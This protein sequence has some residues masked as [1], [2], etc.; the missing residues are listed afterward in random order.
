MGLIGELGMVN[1]FFQI[2]LKLRSIQQ[3]RQG[4]MARLPHQLTRE[5][6]G[7]GHLP[8]H[9]HRTLDIPLGGKVGDYGQIHGPLILIPVAQHNQTGR[10]G[11]ALTGQGSAH[12]ALDRFGAVVPQDLTDIL[13]PLALGHFG[14]PTGE[15]FGCGVEVLNAAFQV[16]QDHRIVDRCQQGGGVSHG[17]GRGEAG[18]SSPSTLRFLPEI[19]GMGITG[20]CRGLEA[21]TRGLRSGRGVAVVLNNHLKGFSQG[22]RLYLLL[23]PIPMDSLLH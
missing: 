11:G 3:P 19:W 5:P 4:I 7:G 20:P 2:K 8:A 15:A 1:R 22:L 12:Q 10:I 18:R 6:P 13:D 17:Q 9:H 16:N 23:I 14:Q 21:G